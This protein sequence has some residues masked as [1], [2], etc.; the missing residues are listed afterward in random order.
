MVLR[1]RSDGSEGARLR[2]QLKRAGLSDRAID[3]AWPAWWSDE[4][5]ASP[6]ARA[7]LRLTVARL[8]GL[9]PKSLIGER[10]EFVWRDNARFKHL[11][12]DDANDRSALTSFCVSVGR[13]LLRATR[14]D[15][16]ISGIGSWA[17]RTS[18]LQS[19]GSVDFAHLLAFCWVGGVPVVYLRVFPL[20]TKS[21]HAIVV[22]IDGR[23]AVML[24]RDSLFPAP[25]AFTLAH[26]LG[27]IQLGH[28]KNTSVLVD[29]ESS[30]DTTDN[31]DEEFAADRF[32]L[33]LLT[34]AGN[35]DIRVSADRFNAAQ[36]AKAV[37]D[38]APA[39]QIEPGVLAMCTAYQTKSWSRGMAALP[40]IYSESKP[41]WKE[42]NRL[43]AAELDWN[44]LCDSEVTYIQNIL[45][46]ND[47][48]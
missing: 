20:T 36:L 5:S 16:D 12:V 21:M 27:H 31:D 48:H 19:S 6:L 42:V 29:S 43:A 13:I 40:L 33:E 15:T 38:I 45:G 4:A 9:Q 10:V 30:A 26:E 2:A 24:G 44:A 32:A 37:L 34:G 11:T 25:V 3:A 18:I 22:R 39:W 47:E 14:Q 46:V 7:E 28:I 35:L 8:L 17:L 23:Y 1:K 41:V